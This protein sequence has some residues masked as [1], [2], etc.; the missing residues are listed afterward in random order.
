MLRAAAAGCKAVKGALALRAWN[1]LY[2]ALFFKVRDYAENG[3]FANSVIG[4]RGIYLRAGKGAV[5]PLFEKMEN[6]L[7]SFGFI[8]Q[9][10]HLFLCKNENHSQNA[11]L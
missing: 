4:K 1:T 8:F 2:F 3:A 10:F 6:E 11:Y 5:R 9:I 7:L